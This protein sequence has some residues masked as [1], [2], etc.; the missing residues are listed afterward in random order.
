LLDNDNGH[1]NLV[2]ARE[3]AITEKM[4]NLAK[5]RFVS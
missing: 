4:F 5:S 1:P 2:N 3:A